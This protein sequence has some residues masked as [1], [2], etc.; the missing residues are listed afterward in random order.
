MEEEVKVEEAQQNGKDSYE[1]EEEEE[2][3]MA[4]VPK[5]DQAAANFQ[6]AALAPIGALPLLKPVP[7]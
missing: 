3:P 7:C 4:H 6:G 1:Q 2:M 5:G